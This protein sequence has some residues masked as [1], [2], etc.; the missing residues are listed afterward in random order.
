MVIIQHSTE[1]L[2]P[3]HWT[4]GFNGDR[5]RNDQPIPEALMV[6]LQVIMSHE[7][8]YGIP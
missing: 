6:S 8:M 2:T 5:W 3:L 4:D 7:F 1:S